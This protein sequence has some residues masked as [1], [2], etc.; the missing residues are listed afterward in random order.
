MDK[1]KR[2]GGLFN[3]SF[4]Y[5]DAILREFEAMYLAKKE[6][7][8]PT[9]IILA[10]VG[11]AGSIYFAYMTYLEGF[12]FTRTCYLMICSV[13]ILL[14]FSRGRSRP[15]GTIEKYRKYYL[16]R[17]VDFKIDEEGVE[18]KLEGQKT[19]A[20][21]KFKEIYGLYE[22]DHSLYFVIK[23]KAYYILS[24]AGLTNGSAEELMK[25]M[26]KK[27]AKTFQHYQT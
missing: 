15:D 20:R 6:I 8:L 14:A 24:K 2:D 27:C 18:M 16:N 3:A 11:V 1:Q 21:S 17:R 13:M 25:Y 9:R 7:T 22:T 23:G 10:L 26:R 19:Y 5:T 4:V 12:R